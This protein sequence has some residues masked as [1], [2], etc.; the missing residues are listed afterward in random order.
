MYACTVFNDVHFSATFL[1]ACFV[2]LMISPVLIFHPLFCAKMRDYS[3]HLWVV[4]LFALFKGL[5]EHTSTN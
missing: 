4:S 1:S 2:C 5:A 3:S